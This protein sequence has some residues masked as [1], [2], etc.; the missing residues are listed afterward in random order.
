MEINRN[1]I[2]IINGMKHTVTTADGL[3]RVQI[4]LRLLHLNEEMDKLKAK[5]QRLLTLRDALD[6][7][8]ERMEQAD[9]CDNLF[10][11]MFG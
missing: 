11:E 5:Q 6:R 4:N 9:A 8:V 3:D 10:E 7:E 1:A 2:R